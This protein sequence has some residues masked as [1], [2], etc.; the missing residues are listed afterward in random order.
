MVSQKQNMSSF[1]NNLT[2]LPDFV[3]RM[4]NK[5]TFLCFRKYFSTQLSKT[6]WP[7]FYISYLEK[8]LPTEVLTKIGVTGNDSKLMHKKIWSG[9]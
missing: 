7:H 4:L 5:L 3:K 6:V 1:L 2:S 9:R 8:E